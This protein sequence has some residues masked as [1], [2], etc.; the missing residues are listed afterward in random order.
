MSRQNSVTHGP[1]A[2]R[3]TINGDTAMAEFTVVFEGDIT[4]LPG[5]PLRY[6]TVY[7]KPVAA[8]IGNAFDKLER[9]VEIEEAA[10]NLIAAINKSADD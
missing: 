8:G 1:A 3:Q 4:K 7:G 9:I 6:E 5:N 10:L 2:S